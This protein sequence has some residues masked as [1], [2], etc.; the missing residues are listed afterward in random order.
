MKKRRTRIVPEV[1]FATAVSAW[2]IPALVTACSSDGTGTGDE[3]G[4]SAGKSGKA[5]SSNGGSGGELVGVA[6]GG[7][8]AYFS[9]AAPFGGRPGAGG[10]GGGVSGAGAGAAGG[11]GAAG[12]AGGGGA[13]GAAGGGGA[14]GTGGR[15][16]AAGAGGRGGASGGAGRG[17]AGFGGFIFS[18]AAPFGGRSGGAGQSASNEKA[19]KPATT[20]KTGPFRDFETDSKLAIS[21]PPVPS[22]PKKES[23]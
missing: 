4:G 8:G 18:V 9:V 13:A 2:V 16:G 22:A 1:V 23:T 12:A 17:N 20:G 21:E 10:A 14:S 15:G 3:H 6:A 5:G 7:F 11:G 19:H